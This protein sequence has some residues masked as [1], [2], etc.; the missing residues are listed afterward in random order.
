MK[1]KL[2]PSSSLPLPVSAGRLPLGTLAGLLLLATVVLLPYVLTRQPAWL[3]EAI[4]SYLAQGPSAQGL[5]YYQ[6]GYDNKPPGILLLYQLTGAFDPGGLWRVRLLQGLLV[7]STC[8]LL[9]FWLGRKVSAPAG[10]WAAGLYALLLAFTPGVWALTEP[11]M[12]LFTAVGFY[13]AY[14]GLRSPRTGFLVGAGLA[15]GVAACFKQVAIFDLLGLLVVVSAAA[16]RG[17]RGASMAAVLGGAVACA[18]VLGLWMVGTG[19]LA[20]FWDSAVLSLLHG[21]GVADW[22][23]RAENLVEYGRWLLPVVQ[24]ALLVALLAYLGPIRRPL[25][26]LLGVWLVTAVVGV[27][28]SGHFL[29]HQSVQLFAP[30][31]ALSG[32]GGAWLWR[33]ARERPG[34]TRVL[35][36]ALLTLLVFAA[37]LDKYRIRVQQALSSRTQIG[38]SA[39][40]RLGHWL[41][42]RVPPGETIYVLGNGMPVYFYAQRRA[43]TRYFHSLLLSS[44]MRQEAAL[45]DLQARPARMLVFAPDYY[46]VQRAFSG[47]VRATLLPGYRRLPTNP[48]FPE[49]EVWEWTWSSERP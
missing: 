24:A 47:R 25:G 28:A 9:L 34:W 33:Q 41:Q 4:F 43:P 26:L 17:R 39:P 7:L 20:E 11:P 2:Q 23:G 1:D 8:L 6:A 12:A 29:H 44:R 3:D 19:Q 14:G 49:Y 10:W 40:E 37:P 48:A 18:G 21:E 22:R 15:L 36:A 32:L 5:P 30:L 38:T 42:E 45:R 27:A 31:A 46:D 35:L 16:G 13:L